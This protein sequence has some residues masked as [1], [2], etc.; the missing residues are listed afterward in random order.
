M[1]ASKVICDDTYSNKS[2]AAVSRGMFT[3]DGVNR[4]ERDLC[5]LLDWRLHIDGGALSRFESR[6]RRSVKEPDSIVAT[7]V[8]VLVLPPPLPTYLDKVSLPDSAA[9]TATLSPAL[10][11]RSLS[12]RHTESAGFASGGTG[13]DKCIK[14]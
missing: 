5:A 8:D 2:W 6:F 14:S 1:L 11:S 10:E 7:T 12:A 3:F 9:T 4:M 13:M